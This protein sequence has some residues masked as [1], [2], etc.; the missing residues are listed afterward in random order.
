MEGKSRR[1]N[2]NHMLTV[3]E[4]GQGCLAGVV[5]VFGQKQGAWRSQGSLP[6]C[7]PPGPRHLA[8]ILPPVGLLPQLPLRVQYLLGG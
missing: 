7:S 4:R 2:E 5:K 8:I 3:R 6:R 1:R